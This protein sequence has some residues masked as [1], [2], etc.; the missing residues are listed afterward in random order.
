MITKIMQSLFG[1]KQARDMRRLLPLVRKTNDFYGKLHDLSDEELRGKTEEFRKRYKDG[2][3]LEKLLP[4]AFAVV[5]E[6]CR[7]HVGKTWNVAGIDIEWDMIPYD[8]QLAGGIVLHQG[9]IAEMATGEGKTLVAILPLYLNALAGQGVHLVTVNDYLA[10]RDSQ[11]MGEIFRFLGMTVGCLDDTRPST[12]ERR[13]Q[14]ECDITYG[15]NHEFGF[16]YLRDNM[17]QEAN[18]VVQ[19][20]GHFFAIVDEVDNILI[21]EARTPLIISGPVDRSTHRY[22]EIKPFV[23]QLIKL[24]TDLITSFVDQADK[25]I[26]D[27]ALTDPERSRS[28]GL[29]L[30]R[31]QRGLPKHR[32][33]MKL[34]QETGV[35]ALME[36]T[37]LDMIQEK[38]MNDVDEG[39]YF[40]I[41]ERQHQI[42]LTEI[43][44]QALSPDNSKLWEMPDLVE[45]A[46]GIDAGDFE[47]IE[48]ADGKKCPLFGRPEV[49]AACKKEDGS[50]EIQN[51][52][53]KFTIPKDQ[54]TGYVQGV[55]IPKQEREQ[56]KDFMRMDQ[57]MQSEKLHNISQLLRAYTL[58]ERDAEYV[59]QD[60]KVI[61]VDEF[62]GRMMAGRRWSDGLHQAVE[63]KENVEIEPETQTL[64]SITLQ[65]FFRLYKKL[66]GMTGTAETEAAEF[67]H[68]YKMDVVVV[69][70]NRPVSRKDQNDLIYKTKREKYNAVIDEIKHLH[71]EGLPVLVGTVNVDVSQLLSRML[72]R[73]KIEHNVLNA[74]NH[75]NEAEIIRF[76]GQKGS[77]TIAT[78]MA[79]RGT[80]IKLGEGVIRKDAKG[81]PYGGLQVLGTERHEARRIDRQ[82][83]GRS[84]R[85][86]DPGRSQFFLSLEDDLMRLFGGDRVSRLMDRLG[87]HEEGEPMMS[88]LL[89]RSVES[90]QKKVESRN[91]EIRKRTLDY[92]EV[93]NSQRKAIYGLRQQALFESDLRGTLLNV[94]FKC[95]EGEI[96]NFG[97]PTRLQSDEWDV[98]GFINY[99]QRCI[100]YTN[101]IELKSELKGLDVNSVLDKVMERVSEGY[102]KKREQLG[103]ELIHN[104]SKWVVLNRID[105]NWIDHLLAIDDLREHIHLRSYGQTDPLVE[106]R[107]EASQFFENL[108]VI[109]Q[110][111]IFE[112]FFLLQPKTEEDVPQPTARI[113]STE[114]RHDKIAAVGE[115]E[116]LPEETKPPENPR[117][118]RPLQP[119]HRKNPVSRNDPCPC[120]SGKK[121]KKCCGALHKNEE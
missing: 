16:D 101:L 51:Y 121:F 19:R 84:G 96:N 93:M 108:M 36:Q 22:D 21:D 14:Y 100:P 53:G 3:T 86:G 80:D 40:V 75:Q 29:L 95:L 112:Q 118:Q 104:L 59:V 9:K 49:R 116:E 41:D 46:A 107:R 47:I 115:D 97:D 8:V 114:V 71:S 105:S 34:L 64:A 113:Q 2:E 30:L 26:K 43:G 94:F 54:I 67:N 18:Q 78:N 99:V 45:D 52:H 81:R 35:K 63:C 37:E 44:R 82:L 42:D 12:E 109:V 50:V 23:Q 103:D 76:A 58:Y 10:R 31:C 5:K 77:V 27:G 25:L 98:D 39:V 15:T 60:Q 57:A 72:S 106:F 83:R 65:N 56:I 13:A 66:S 73:E 89:T 32:R 33:F 90:A 69:P 62:T 6:A 48:L 20:R 117:V 24:Q 110:R 92:D 70:T 55:D 87:A 111:E 85:Q 120:G 91:F 88:S 61:I 4:E 74:K 68:T 102:D 7:R 119:I 17:V 28:L 11:W 1:N 38:K 79:G